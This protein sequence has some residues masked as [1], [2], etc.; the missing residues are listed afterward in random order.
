MS[1]QVDPRGLMVK[2]IESLQRMEETIADG[3]I[4]DLAER[5][6]TLLLLET[7]L[8]VVKEHLTTTL[9]ERM[10]EDEMTVTGV[11][12]VRR[13]PRSST[14]WID[15]TSK[16]RLY[17]DV[18]RA[19]I[20]KIAVDPMTGEVHPPLSNTVR[21]TFEMLQKVFSFGADP[22]AAFR[23]ELGLSPDDYRAKRMTGWT[24]DMEEETL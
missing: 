14:T 11:G 22:K 1:A 23:K 17:D 10:E 19:V 6:D 4:R 5:L 24:V 8:D 3:T 2:F 21:A 20:H 7:A 13:R 16:T 15:D 18:I 9:A 12:I